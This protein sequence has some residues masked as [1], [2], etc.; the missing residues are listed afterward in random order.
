MWV[1]SFCRRERL[2][3]NHKHARV[4]ERSKLSHPRGLWFVAFSSGRKAKTRERVRHRGNARYLVNFCSTAL[5]VIK[6]SRHDAQKEASFPDAVRGAEGSGHDESPKNKEPGAMA[7]LDV[8][9]MEKMRDDI[10]RPAGF[11]PPR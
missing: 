2:N 8:V 11:I 3:A 5:C 6:N 9:G 7:R 10:S 1:S 4:P